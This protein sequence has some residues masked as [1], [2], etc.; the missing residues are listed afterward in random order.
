MSEHLILSWW[1][2]KLSSQLLLC[3]F[4]LQI[5]IEKQF[6]GLFHTLLMNLQKLLT[7]RL[8]MGSHLSLKSSS[9][10]FKASHTFTLFF[11]QLCV[12]MMRLILVILFELPVFPHQNFVVSYEILV[13]TNQ[14]IH[15]L[16]HFILLFQ[17]HSMNIS[18]SLILLTQE[19]PKLLLDWT[20]TTISYISC[21]CTT[22]IHI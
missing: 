3:S 11:D 8:V 5:C 4:P 20:K 14:K 15:F 16:L 10:L 12:L 18:S 13:L 21:I 7:C 17:V 2:L 6:F 1:I 22:A 19:L 9:F